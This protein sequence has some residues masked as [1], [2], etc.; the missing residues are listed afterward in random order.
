MICFH[1]HLFIC[2]RLCVNRCICYC[3]FDLFVHA[4]INLLIYIDVFIVFFLSFLSDFLL[5][6]IRC[7]FCVFSMTSLLIYIRLLLI[8]DWYYLFARS[9]LFGSF[10][11]SSSITSTST[12]VNK[13][14]LEAKLG[15]HIHG[16]RQYPICQHVHGKRPV[17]LWHT[18]G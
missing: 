3:L 14:L 17:L 5:T 4:F 15:Q 12:V 11:P 2:S 18:R 9:I 8:V 6:I 7:F 13:S 10:S 1:L 16:K